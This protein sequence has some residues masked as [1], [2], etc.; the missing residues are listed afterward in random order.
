MAT[1]ALNSRHWNHKHPD[2]GSLFDRFNK[3]QQERQRYFDTVPIA[4]GPNDSDRIKLHEVTVSAPPLYLDKDLGMAYNN[5]TNEY[6][7][8][9]SMEKAKLRDMPLYP[10]SGALA[11]DWRTFAAEMAIPTAA[12]GM[13][14]LIP[15]TAELLGGSKYGQ[16][17][18][19][20]I[21][22]LGPGSKEWWSLPLWKQIG[23]FALDAGFTAK[24]ANDFVNEPSVENAAYTALGLSP[25]ISPVAIKGY[26]YLNP[27]ISNFTKPIINKFNHT[28][29]DI[30]N[31]FT[32]NR[33]LRDAFREEM[34]RYYKE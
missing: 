7:P 29:H 27:K 31:F 15:E 1:F 33:R 30:Y 25:Y 32:A 11:Q 34:H 5:D 9:A 16:Y 22:A 3:L 21:K 28:K 13:F 10:A 2:G 18:Y 17:I 20:G 26:E 23:T 24:S 4:N 14:G 12:S 6:Y 8:A 19:N